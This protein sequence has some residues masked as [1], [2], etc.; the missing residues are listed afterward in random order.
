MLEVNTELCKLINLTEEVE[1]NLKEAELIGSIWRAE[2]ESADTPDI[3]VIV[4]Y[5]ES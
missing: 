4:V 5:S 3:R 1:T 2:N